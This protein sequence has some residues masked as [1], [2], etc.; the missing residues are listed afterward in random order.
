MLNSLRKDLGNVIISSQPYF[1][2]FL[3]RPTIT[4]YL[5]HIYRLFT[6]FNSAHAL[7]SKKSAVF[8]NGTVLTRNVC[9]IVAQAQ[10]LGLNKLTVSVIFWP[11]QLWRRMYRAIPVPYHGG[12]RIK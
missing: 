8:W 1:S 12:G 10:R 3:K 2:I 11:E 9:Q 5:T 6:I 7:V 4:S